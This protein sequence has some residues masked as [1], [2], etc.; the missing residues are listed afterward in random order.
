MQVDGSLTSSKADQ[1]QQ[2]EALQ[3]LQQSLQEV[4]S[5]HPYKVEGLAICLQLSGQS[6][7]V[8]CMLSVRAQ[9]LPIQLCQLRAHM[10]HQIVLQCSLCTPAGCTQHTPHKACCQQADLFCHTVPNG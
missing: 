4:C 6:Y 9:L 2:I 7:E 5:S 1:L 3:T 8:T 10:R